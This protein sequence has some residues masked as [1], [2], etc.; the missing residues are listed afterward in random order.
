[1]KPT[2]KTSTIPGTLNSAATQRRY[3]DQATGIGQTR[4]ESERTGAARAARVAAGSPAP[5]TL[6]VRCG[7]VLR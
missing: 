4:A 1:M 3:F 5:G 7:P 2:N 6:I